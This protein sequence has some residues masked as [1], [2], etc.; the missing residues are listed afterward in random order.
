MTTEPPP[1]AAA[2]KVESKESLARASKLDFK[3]VNEVWDD[4]AYKYT[5]EESPKSVNKANELDQYVFVIRARIKKK[6]SAATVYI[7]IKSEYLRDV[8]RTVLKSVYR[9]SV[10]QNLLYHYLPKLKSLRSSTDP[11]DLIG[12]PRVGKTLTTKALSEHLQRLLYTIS[13][14]DLSH[15]VAKLEKQLSLIFELTDH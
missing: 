2:K 4:K 14:R 9:I 12:P 13:A 3:A 15:D 10:K 6:I 7:D 11:L 1:P 8:L 5:I